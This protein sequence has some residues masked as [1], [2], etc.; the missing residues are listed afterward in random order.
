MS[1]IQWVALIVFGIFVW[2]AISV[3][4]NMKKRWYKVYLANNDV[5]LMYRTFRERWWSNEK[6]AK[7]MDDNGHEI[8]F[9]SEAHWVLFWEY[10]PD[11]QVRSARAEIAKIRMAK[12][13]E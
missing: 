2:V 5:R 7:F 8:S 9:P 10:I 13:E 11:D 6:V 1:V 3:G 4:L 12:E